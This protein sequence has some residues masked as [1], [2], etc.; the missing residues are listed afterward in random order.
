MKASATASRFRQSNPFLHLPALLDL[1]VITVLLIIYITETIALTALCK[2]ATFKLIH[3]QQRKALCQVN[4][5]FTINY[6]TA[7]N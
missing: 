7:R 3:L 4:F 2:F 6:H 1:K 5:T